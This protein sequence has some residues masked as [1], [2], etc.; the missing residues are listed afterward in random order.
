MVRDDVARDNDRILCLR[1]REGLEN[2]D[3]GKMM[4]SS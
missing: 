2:A 4:G 1:R 3:V